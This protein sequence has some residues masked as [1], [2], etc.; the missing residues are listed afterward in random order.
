M[1]KHFNKF[2]AS[3]KGFTVIELIVVITIIAILSA[4]I[5]LSVTQ[6]INKGKDSNISGN[7]AVLVPAGEVYYNIENAAYGD[8]YT[9][10]C[11][12][13]KNSAIKNA[14]SQMPQNPTG[15]CLGGLTPGLCCNV[16]PDG[17]SWAACA[18]EFT[19]NTQAYCVDS[20]GVKKE[21]LNSSC[22]SAIVSCD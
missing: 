13:D 9:G 12:P 2:S 7:L 21:I 18:Q 8:G 1:N 16:A 5:L 6:Y 11:D 20:R 15:D 3:Q 14:I 17:D 10:F 4:V 19:Y 22:T